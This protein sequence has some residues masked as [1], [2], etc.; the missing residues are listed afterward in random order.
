[1]GKP[2]PFT[3]SAIQN[4][5]KTT[6]FKLMANWF[7]LSSGVFC[8]CVWPSIIGAVLSMI[9]VYSEIYFHYEI[10]FGFAVVVLDCYLS[11]INYIFFCFN[12][13]AFIL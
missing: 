3:L 6:I 5:I 13:L 10:Y 2:C 1:M 9:K 12:K 8:F 7:A 4:L 11:F